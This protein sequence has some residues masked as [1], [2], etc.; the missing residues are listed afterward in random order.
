MS[1]FIFEQNKIVE[2]MHNTFTVLCEKSKMVSFTF[3]IMKN[4]NLLLLPFRF[5]VKLICCIAFGSASSACCLRKSIAI[6][7]MFFEMIIT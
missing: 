2:H 4:I 3:P 7:M 1:H 5:S 6:F